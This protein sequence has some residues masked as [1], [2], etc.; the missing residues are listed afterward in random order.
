MRWTR[1]QTEALL[2]RDIADSTE[3]VNEILK[4]AET[5]IAHIAAETEIDLDKL[6]SQEND[7]DGEEAD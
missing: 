5:L 4:E 1:Q 3:T 2:E 6:L 7:S